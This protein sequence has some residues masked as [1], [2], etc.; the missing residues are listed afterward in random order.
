MLP[1]WLP[2]SHR[3]PER[4]WASPPH[5]RLLNSSPAVLLP[6][7]LTGGRSCRDREQTLTSWVVSGGI[8]RPGGL[9]AHLAPNVKLLKE[10]L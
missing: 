1:S 7:A 8:W 6:G 10:D 2:M 4:L 3:C 5:G 9:E